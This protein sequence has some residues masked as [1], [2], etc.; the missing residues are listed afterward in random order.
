MAAL[1]RKLP[2]ES[3]QLRIIEQLNEENENVGIEL[4]HVRREA[5]IWRKRLSAVVDRISSEQLSTLTI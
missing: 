5:E 4:E 2:D 1:P 3:E